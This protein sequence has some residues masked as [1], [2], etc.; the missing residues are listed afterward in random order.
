MV[1]A[2]TTGAFARTD[3][4]GE[5]GRDRRQRADGMGLESQQFSG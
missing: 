5:R 3:D 2:C 1:T 4:H